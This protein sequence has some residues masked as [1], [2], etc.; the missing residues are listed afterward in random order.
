MTLGNG[1]PH[2]AN[3]RRLFPPQPRFLRDI[4]CV[5][6]SLLLFTDCLDSCSYITTTKHGNSGLASSLRCRYGIRPGHLS[7]RLAPD[8]CQWVTWF[9]PL[10][11][12]L[13]ATTPAGSW[14]GEPRLSLKYHQ[15]SA[16]I[17]FSPCIYPLRQTT[18]KPEKFVPQSKFRA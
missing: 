2:K 10:L 3:T 14:N 15:Q 1:G 11:F 6:N 16:V 4:V 8:R 18:D 9:G 17:P 12:S 13:P 5:M 7:G